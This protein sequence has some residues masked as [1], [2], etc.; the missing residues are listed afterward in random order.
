[1]MKMDVHKPSISNKKINTMK[2]IIFLLVLIAQVFMGAC[3]EKSELCECHELQLKMAK[4][5]NALDGDLEAMKTIKTKNAAKIESCTA[6]VAKMK[7]KMK[8]LTAEEKEKKKLEYYEECP[9]FEE[10]ME[11]KKKK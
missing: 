4:E 5:F 6:I 1:M 11:M 10:L 9:A 7:A 2:K 3:Q 8:D